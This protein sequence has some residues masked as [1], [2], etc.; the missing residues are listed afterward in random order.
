MRQSCKGAAKCYDIIDPEEISAY[1]DKNGT[2]GIMHNWWEDLK[3]VKLEDI[4]R[5]EN[6]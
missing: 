2:K 1:V 3:F 4:R 5:I 6:R